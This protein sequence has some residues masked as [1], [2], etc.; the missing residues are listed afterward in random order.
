M[1]KTFTRTIK[2]NLT[3]LIV[4][5][6]VLVVA[7]ALSVTVSVIDSKEEKK[8]KSRQAILRSTDIPKGVTVNNIDIGG[9]NYDEAVAKLRIEA[10]A[11]IKSGIKFTLVYGEDKYQIDSNSF[12]IVF[13]TEDLVQ[14]ALELVTESG[15][16]KLQAYMNKLKTEGVNYEITYTIDASKLEES[17]DMKEIF[18]AIYVAPKNAIAK[19]KSGFKASYTSVINGDPFTFERDV[20][21]LEVDREKLID[22]MI[23]GIEDR[24]FGKIEV[25]TKPVEADVTI[26]ELKANTV[27]LSYF[28]TEFR[29]SNDNRVHNVTT[30]AKFLNG[31]CVKPGDTFS[32]EGTIGRRVD[33]NIWRP[34]AAV[35]DGGAA[36]EEQLG[37]G[38]CQVSTT[39]YNAIVKADLPIVFRK[40]HSKASTYVDPGLDA[41]INT[42]TID[43]KWKNDKDYDIY[44]FA[45]TDTAKNVYCAVYGPAFPDK[46]DRIEFESTFTKK[47]DP[48]ATEY[49]VNNALREGEWAVKN[50]AITGYI[51]NS[52]AYYYKGRTLV[53]TKPIDE[54]NY[55]MHPK[56]IYVYPGYVKGTPLAAS[57]EMKLNSEGKFVRKYN[58]PTPAPVPDPSPT[59]NNDPI[60]EPTPVPPNEQP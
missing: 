24:K 49:I 44:I 41:T 51:Y 6:V 55:K 21:G 17:K 60:I 59:P 4:T 50:E 56:R 20:D 53:D 19:I 8:E 5:A 26:D 2:S 22:E 38:V 45:W 30:A 23:K 10:E 43:F 36:T 37:G 32:M 34:A 12:T 15:H 33:P 57:K 13:N 47:I 3:L 42:D 40:N 31:T 7:I 1:N 35:V 16:D 46:F 27:L 25:P 14:E 52:F 29:S 48:T 11:E 54:S 39:L 18:D 58:T 9:L 28:D